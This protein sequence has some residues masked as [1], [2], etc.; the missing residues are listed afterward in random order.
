MISAMQ[1]YTQMFNEINTDYTLSTEERNA[2]LAELQERFS[3]TML[4]LQE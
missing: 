2:R 4:Y 3:E 1:Q